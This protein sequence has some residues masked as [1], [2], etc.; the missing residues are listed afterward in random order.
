[1]ED[2]YDDR[3]RQGVTRSQGLWRA[4]RGFTVTQDIQNPEMLNALKQFRCFGASTSDM[5]T[6]AATSRCEMVNLASGFVV[7]C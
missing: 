6:A 5:T 1:M 2:T 7:K 3:K 4:G